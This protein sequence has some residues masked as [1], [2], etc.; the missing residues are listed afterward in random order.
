MASDHRSRF[1][2]TLQGIQEPPAP[3]LDQVRYRP[4]SVDIAMAVGKGNLEFDA[5]YVV[6]GSLLS[7]GMDLHDLKLA[8]DPYGVPLDLFDVALVYIAAGE[9][10][11]GLLLA[12]AGPTNGFTN[13][14]GT[15]A[16]LILRAGDV[17]IGARLTAGNCQV[18][19][20]NKVLELQ[21]TGGDADYTL[22]VWGRRP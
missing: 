12:S 16:N 10:N 8:L 5:L 18:L 19:A 6:E 11:A 4:V 1:A 14:F 7:G 17:E 3:Y 2:L 20:N 15:V 9:Q 21:A 13:Y 22:M